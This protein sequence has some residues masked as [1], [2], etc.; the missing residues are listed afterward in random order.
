MRVIHTKENFKSPLHLACA[1]NDV[2]EFCKYVMFAD[3][4]MYATDTH[5]MVKQHFDFCNVID[6]EN[7]NG[8]AIHC[9]DFR[10]IFKADRIIAKEKGVEFH[11]FKEN[12]T[13]HFD[14]KTDVRMPD[15]DLVIKRC[16]TV[17]ETSC[18]Q[19]NP[20]FIEVAAK[21]IYDDN[22][23]DGLVFTICD[24]NMIKIESKNYDNQFAIIMTIPREKY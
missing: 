22:E 12:L 24:Q 4:Y 10:R 19:V 18:V 1:K 15:F 14:Y 6:K 7:L 23:R 21:C 11:F 17:I 13:G 20:K 16:E 8:K 2:H 3:N 9:E 5:V